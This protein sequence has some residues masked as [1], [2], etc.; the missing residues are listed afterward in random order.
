M[1]ESLA[2]AVAAAAELAV[3]GSGLY[4]NN[5]DTDLKAQKEL[6]MV[7]PSK[8]QDDTSLP[9]EEE[10]SEEEEED[11]QVTEKRICKS[12]ARN[13][14][15]ARRTR[16]RKKAQLEKLQDKVKGLQK[17]SSVLKQ[18]LE[19]YSIASILA[20]LGRSGT[21]DNTVQTLLQE[22]NSHAEE[23]ENILPQGK[24][25]RFVSV[26]ITEKQPP[27]PLQ[28]KIG[29]QTALIGGGRT[30]INWKTGVYSDERGIKK[31]LSSKQLENL[32][33]VPLF[34]F[35]LSR[36]KLKKIRV[37]AVTRAKYLASE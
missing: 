1:N 11:S 19:E 16:I 5:A 24:R 25:N 12:R 33:Y 3:N 26:D 6:A 10:D 30:H 22:A 9:E 27:Q 23:T 32:R 36:S 28:I 20:G 4:Y 8:T 2:A 37:M 21:Q 34:S 13:R 35:S 7:T 29:G 18:S 31:Q 14:E 15:H 17:E